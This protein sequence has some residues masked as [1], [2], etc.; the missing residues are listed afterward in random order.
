LDL[1]AL[2][3]GD[4]TDEQ[5]RSAIRRGWGERVDRGAEDRLEQHARGVLAEPGELRADPHLEMHTRGG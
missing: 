4:A 5:L 1:R 3:R 2:L